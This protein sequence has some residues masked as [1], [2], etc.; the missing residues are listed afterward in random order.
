MSMTGVWTLWAESLALRIVDLG[1]SQRMRIGYLEFNHRLKKVS[2]KRDGF[3]MRDHKKL[4]AEIRSAQCSGV[5][6]YQLPLQVW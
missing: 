4:T 6:D 2:D 1:K 5:T 3:F